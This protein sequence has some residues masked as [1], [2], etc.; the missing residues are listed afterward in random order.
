VF[1]RRA[2][3]SE[4]CTVCQVFLWGSNNDGSPGSSMSW[5]NAARSSPHPS[6]LSAYP[7]LLILNQTIDTA[8]YPRSSRQWLQVSTGGVHVIA[9]RFHAAAVTASKLLERITL[10]IV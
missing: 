7:A 8:Y 10:E 6:K 3:T 9:G 4:K 5:T 1:F 2:Y